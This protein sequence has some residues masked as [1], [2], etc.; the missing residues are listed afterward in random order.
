MYPAP[1]VISQVMDQILPYLQVM[2]VPVAFAC[3]L[4]HIRQDRVDFWERNRGHSLWTETIIEIVKCLVKTNASN[5]KL[6]IRKSQPI[7]HN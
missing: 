1:P 4:L 5:N 3:N 2:P 6:I 7:K